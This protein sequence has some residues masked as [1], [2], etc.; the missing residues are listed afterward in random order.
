MKFESSQSRIRQLQIDVHNSLSSPLS[1]GLI[2]PVASY[3]Q[4]RDSNAETRQ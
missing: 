4:G 2:L 3:M 1:N